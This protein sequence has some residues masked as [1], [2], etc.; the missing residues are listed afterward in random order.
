MR[1]VRCRTNH[2][3]NSL[4]YA[5][6][7]PT[8]SWI[9]EDAQSRRQEFARVQV[10]SKENMEEVIYD[11][12]KKREISS[13]GVELPIHLM[14]RTMYFW[15]V[16]VWGDQEESAESEVNWFETGKMEEAWSA[17]W[18]SMDSKEIHPLV[19]RKFLIE[20]EIR[21]ARAYVCGL[22]AYEFYINGKKA[23]D[24]YLAPGCT[25]ADEWIQSYT[26]DVTELL[27]IGE[28]VAG[29]LLGNGWN[30]N[31]RGSFEFAGKSYTDRFFFLAEIHVEY[32]DGSS[33]ILKSDQ[34]WKWNESW[35][36][37]SSI[38]D[39]ESWD[40][41]DMTPDD[42]FMEESDGWKNVIEQSPEKIGKIEDRRSLPIR[43]HEQ[44]KPVEI[45]QTAKGETI[46]DFGQNMAGWVRFTL[47]EKE[48]KKVTLSYGEILQDGDL[49]R[50]NLR[51][52]K[53]QFSCI[54]DGKE[55]S[56]EPHFTYYG[57]R[58]VKLEGFEKPIDPEDFTACAVYSDL[59]ETG[60][61]TT[62]D[63]VVNRLFLNA[64]WGQKSNFMDT[65]TDCPQRDERMGWAGD[66]QVFSGTAI[67]NMD[68]YAFYAKFLH[69][70]WYDQKEKNGM[71]GNVIPSFIPKKKDQS[72]PYYGGSAVWG[73]C[74]TILPWNLYLYYG[75][76]R[77]L[78]DQYKSMTGWVDWVNGRIEKNSRRGL[79]EGDYQW[80]D[81]LALDGPV[82]DG[83][84]GGTDS[85]FIA[86]AYF[87]HSADIVSKTAKILGNTKAEEK[88]RSMSEKAKKA[89]FS[90]YFSENGRTTIHTQTAY[91][92]ALHFDLVPEKL[93]ER[94]LKD[95]L[96]LLQKTDFHLQ[97]G[98]AGTSL[99]CTTLS[100]NGQ[101]RTAYEIFMKEDCPSWLYAVKMGATTIWERWDS[102]Q[103]DGRIISNGMNSLNHYSYGSVVEWMYR[104][105]CGIQP[106][107]DSPGFSRFLLHPQPDGSL[108]G[109]KA[110][111]D[112]PK[113]RIAIGWKRTE[114]EEM[115]LKIVVPFDTEAE[116]CLPDA[117]KNS[118]N[119]LE[120]IPLRQEGTDVYA[121]L[122]AGTYEISYPF[123][124]KYTFC[125]STQNRLEELKK[126][127]DTRKI[128]YEE[129]PMLDMIPTEIFSENQSFSEVL[130]GTI[131]LSGMVD[132]DELEKRLNERL[133]TIPCVTHN[134]TFDL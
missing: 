28:N 98:F 69:D 121:V 114:Q 123:T 134:S 16:T 115:Y 124:R 91:V 25:T 82:K 88:Y 47:R 113:G 96:K 125:Y 45:I 90:E 80:G 30:K 107:D 73:D 29:A 89:I 21:K 59:R 65:P 120:E 51:T 111:Y 56:V 93:R 24:G 53:Q 3:E 33:S 92:L 132:V 116:L 31:H 118:V 44:R 26:Y 131:R 20:K 103:P 2:L 119:G 48:G 62:S 130:N 35:I 95:F 100:E 41:R 52:A 70:L 39:G 99:L 67:F 7:H 60:K 55:R 17:S 74:A 5:L 37:N 34:N 64:M 102:I 27:H 84:E 106:I 13:L 22:G 122:E 61:I 43:I 40:L 15:K 49:Y 83:T 76:T 50:E 86:T 57:F 54:A 71:V 85:T 38:Y 133:G 14:P 127:V 94:V 1:I 101:S 8:V 117:E 12:G 108:T 32:K 79:W 87:K 46:L 97:T 42:W 81:W 11:S 4:G 66:T 129:F 105:V 58:Y 77:I 75:D 6:S 78:K 109:A 36:R 72:M 126:N 110:E 23:E 18:I 9:T 63:P 19:R 104:Y 68:S 10:S 112:S 128:L